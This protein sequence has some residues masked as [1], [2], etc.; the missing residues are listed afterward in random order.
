MTI[1]GIVVLAVV[2]IAGATLVALG[3]CASSAA[4]EEAQSKLEL[5]AEEELDLPRGRRPEVKFPLTLMGATSLV[6]S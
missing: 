2:L 1:I 4:R 3:L 6:V 5:P